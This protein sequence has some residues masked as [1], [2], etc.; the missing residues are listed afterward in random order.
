ME[1]FGNDAGVAEEKFIPREALADMFYE[2]AIDAHFQIGVTACR[3]LRE[4]GPC[5][6]SRKLRA[7]NVPPFR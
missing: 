3:L 7:F 5:L 4:E 6:H 1:R 2:E